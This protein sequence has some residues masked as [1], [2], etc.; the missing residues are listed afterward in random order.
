MPP[1]DPPC[2]A[3][4]AFVRGL[5]DML[6][7]APAVGAWALVTGVAMAQS[8]LALH[9]SV[10]LSLIAYA[11]SAQLA[12]LPLL[13]AGAPVAVSVLTALMVNLRFVI[14]SAAVAP[15]FRTLPLGRRLAVGYL[16]G[17]ISF[18]VYSRAER[19]FPDRQGKLGYYFGVGLAM[20]AVWHAGS[21]V[22][23][24][25]AAAIPRD[26]GLDFAGLLALLGLW[27]PSFASR[28]TLAGS[29]VAAVLGVALDGLPLRLGVVPAILGGI[30]VAVLLDR[31]REAAT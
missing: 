11:G 24:F 3:C 13:V 21:L 4:E 8:G 12:A 7:A 16:L 29:V 27:V 28:P 19:A 9:Q 20:Y 23:L 14:Y 18:V 15:T 6:P 10:G 30:A 1:A 17:D 25:A 26:W 22:G 31:R 2:E 5:R